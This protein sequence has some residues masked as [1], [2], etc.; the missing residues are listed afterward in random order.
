MVI[1]F[2]SFDSKYRNKERLCR[3]GKAVNLNTRRN[4][5]ETKFYGFAGRGRIIRTTSDTMPRR[6]LNKKDTAS[7]AVSR[8][9]AQAVYRDADCQAGAVMASADIFI[10]DLRTMAV[11]R[12]APFWTFCIYLTKADLVWK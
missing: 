10:A 1:Y 5:S 4:C 8:I 2:Q 6:R 12:T 7:T 3:W 11:M 9:I